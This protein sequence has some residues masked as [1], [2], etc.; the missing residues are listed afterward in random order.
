M[1]VLVRLLK[2]YKEPLSYAVPPHY[3]ALVREGSVVL[4]PLRKQEVAGLVVKVLH[5]HKQQAYVVR[6]ISSLFKFPE[7]ARFFAFIEK[8]AQLYFTDAARLWA[9]L[10]TFVFGAGASSAEEEASVQLPFSSSHTLTDEQSAAVYAVWQDVSAGLY[11][12]TLLQGVT[13]SGKTEVYQE[14]IARTIA[15]GKSVIFLCPEISLARYMQA[16]LAQYFNQSISIGSWHAATGACERKQVWQWAL[17]GMPMLL[18]GVHQPVLLPLQNLGLII[19]DEEHDGG[20][21]EKQ[22]PKINSKHVALLRA[23]EYGI[24][25]VLGSATPSVATLHYAAQQ[26]WRHCFLKTRFGGTFPNVEHVLLPSEKKRPHF[27]VSKA[28]LAGL[29]D[30]VFAGRQALVYLNRRGYGFFSQCSDCGFIFQCSACAV[31]L[32]LHQEEAGGGF[33]RS[34]ECHYCSFRMPLPPRCTQCQASTDTSKSKGIGTQQL[35]EILKKLLPSEEVE[36]LQ[37]LVVLS[38]AKESKALPEKFMVLK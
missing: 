37:T 35:V 29:Q 10:S 2:G 1:H 22:H 21:E 11:R 14:L 9:R 15:A 7:D 23:R 36:R 32:T 30:T 31:S 8:V 6:E 25:I 28:L 26:G 34:L 24:P 20:F 12:P 16:R 27:W 5:T 18:I 38:T 3:Q 33:S 19:I 13:G 17:A 4:V